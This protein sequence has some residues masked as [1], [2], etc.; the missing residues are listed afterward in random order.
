MQSK[1]IIESGYQTLLE[2]ARQTRHGK[3][4]TPYAKHALSAKMWLLPNGILQPLNGR[5]HHDYLREHPTLAAKLGLSNLDLS[6]DEQSIRIRALRKGFIR[7]AYESKF[8]RLVVEGGAKFWT[9]QV[10]DTIFMLVADNAE[11]I[12][13]MAVNLFDAQ[14]LVIKRADT[15]LFSMDDAEIWKIYLSSR[16]PYVKQYRCEN[17]NFACLESKRSAVR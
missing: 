15:Q 4:T 17:L 5:Y 6:G 14:G 11:K 10:K 1:I 12:D 9:K 2:F 8:G 3:S 16:N 13:S 7:V